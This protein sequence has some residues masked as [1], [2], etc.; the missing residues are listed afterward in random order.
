M[1]II[2]NTVTIRKSPNYPRIQI[3]QKAWIVVRC[4]KEIKQGHSDVMNKETKWVNNENIIHFK[5]QYGL[6]SVQ[7]LG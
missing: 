7:W 2:N 5:Y 6:T 1:H 3:T 4:N